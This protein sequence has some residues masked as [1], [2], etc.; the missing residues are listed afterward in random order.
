MASFL[1]EL[2]RARSAVAGQPELSWPRVAGASLRRAECSE[3]SRDRRRRCVR[4][5]V[6]LVQSVR[7]LLRLPPQHRFIE[8]QELAA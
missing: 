3:Q 2:A 6:G 1:A 7:G 4:A 5:G 8:G